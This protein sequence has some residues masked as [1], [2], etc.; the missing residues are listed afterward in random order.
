MTAVERP[1]RDPRQRLGLEGERAAEEALVG[2][3]MTI[4]DRR[5]RLRLGEIDLVALDGPV[6]VFVEVKTRRTRSH[7]APAHSVTARK[8][9]RIARVAALWLAGR[10]WS[11]RPCR[12]DVVQVFAGRQGGGRIDHIRDAFRLWSRP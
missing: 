12:F 7:G 6:V 1:R 8:R 4:L 2:A 3:G 11:D 9:S 10:G 5:F